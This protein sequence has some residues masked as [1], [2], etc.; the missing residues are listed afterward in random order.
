MRA[1]RPC[2]QLLV[3]GRSRDILRPDRH[4]CLSYDPPPSSS[5]GGLGSGLVV[6]SGV[7]PRAGQPWA[8]GC[9][10]SRARMKRTPFPSFA[11]STAPSGLST[12]CGFV[13]RPNPPGACARWLG[14]IS[15]PSRFF[16]LNPGLHNLQA[17]Q[18]CPMHGST[19]IAFHPHA[20]LL[21]RAHFAALPAKWTP[22]PQPAKDGEYPQTS[23]AET[24]RNQ[25]P[26]RDGVDR[27]QPAPARSEQGGKEQPDQNGSA[28]FRQIIPESEG[29]GDWVEGMGCRR[30]RESRGRTIVD[31][32][33]EMR[34]NRI[35]SI[36]QHYQE[37]VK[38]SF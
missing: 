20:V 33:L 6:V 29:Q 26:H 30:R 8:L 1:A 25:Q 34:N 17:K 14:R 27:P 22:H 4:G 13:T 5:S 16:F 15:V 36:Q 2:F 21:A 37:P 12:I 23:S 19:R 11:L 28:D 24:K 3:V 18:T 32:L 31:A 38:W 10:W 7:A 9:P 35:K